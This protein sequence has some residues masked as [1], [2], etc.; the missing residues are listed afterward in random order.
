MDKQ[1]DKVRIREQL[2][3]YLPM[4]IISDMFEDRTL[5][6]LSDILYYAVDYYTGG[7]EEA[8]KAVR[9]ERVDT[10]DQLLDKMRWWGTAR[11]DEI[12]ESGIREVLE[13]YLPDDVIDDA[14][15]NG[16]PADLGELLR[17]AVEY[18]TDSDNR[19]LDAVKG[20]RIESVDDLMDHITWWYN[21][22][23]SPTAW[24]NPEQGEEYGVGV[25]REAGEIEDESAE[26]IEI[27]EQQEQKE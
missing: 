6:G 13:S 20:I 17:M 16:I 23:A 18:F 8:L 22:T 24:L 25:E 19:A 10:V 14:L 27:Q 15:R 26:E 4:T 3:P 1:I 5:T 11:E 12:D 21:T 9:K 7:N 2:K